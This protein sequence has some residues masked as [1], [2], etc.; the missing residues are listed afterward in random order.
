MLRRATPRYG[1]T[2]EP[3]TPYQKAA[4]VWDER[5]GSARVQA[6]SWRLMAFACLGLAGGFAGALVWQSVQSRI[7]PYVVEVDQA[8][9][10]R[11]VAP[12]SETY[13]PSDAQIAHALARFIENV[14]EIPIDPVILRRNWMRA[15][16]VATERAA[17]TLNAYARESDPFAEIGRRNVTVEVTSVLRSS[18][19]SFDL[20]WRERSYENGVPVSTTRHSA[21]ISVRLEPPRNEASL[22]ANPL[23]LYVHGL[24]WSRDHIS[25]EDS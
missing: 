5:M 9:A 4:Q 19:T 6:R 17:A 15:Y 1:T 20:R 10:V 14:R 11:A 3:V 23:G 16:A 2:P 25:G 24:H 21:V 18:Q 8:G 12:A 7:T 13:E 22:R